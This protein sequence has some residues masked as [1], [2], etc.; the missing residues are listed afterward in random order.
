MDRKVILVKE[1]YT[2]DSLHQ[3]IPLFST[4]TVW[5]DKQSITRSEWRAAGELGLQPQFTL[6]VQK[7]NYHEEKIVE[8]DGKQ[9]SV[10]RTYD[11]ENSDQVELYCEEKA[12]D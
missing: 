5:A 9:Y 10:Y 7:I 12:G 6:K 8:M 1:T 4:T 11:D 2:T 3:F